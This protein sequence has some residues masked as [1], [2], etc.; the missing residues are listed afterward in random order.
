MEASHMQGNRLWTRSS[1]EIALQLR[2]IQYQANQ[3]IDYNNH[4]LASMT[5]HESRLIISA[6]DQGSRNAKR[7]RSNMHAVRIK[8]YL[9]IIKGIIR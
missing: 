2:R 4:N 9:L 6:N 3:S 5:A 1:M 8:W 7:N